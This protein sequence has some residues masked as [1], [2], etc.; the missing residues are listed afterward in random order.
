MTDAL[1]GGLAS[2]MIEA[3][4]VFLAL[5]AGAAYVQTVTG[6]AFGLVLVAAIALTGLMPLPEAAIVINLLTFA[7]AAIVLGQGWH[8]VDWRR[9]VFSV[10]GATPS[11][12][13][14]YLALSYLAD[15]SMDALRLVLGLVIAV[16][17]LPLIRRPEPRPETSPDWTFAAFGA[18]GGIMGGLFSTAGPP[19]VYHFYRQPMSQARIR[20]TLVSIFVLNASFRLGLVGVSGHWQPHT[21]VWALPAVPVVIGATWCA[22][23]WPPPLSPTSIRRI[24]FILLLASGLSLAAPAIWAHI[25]M[26]S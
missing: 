19:L 4:P 17:S 25:F 2:H 9:M 23:R 22:R 3:I 5:A 8:N 18:I 26:R 13:L 14:G 1:T 20:E 21:L 10:L 15:V 6:F 11:I 16:S 24:A 7:N 12:A